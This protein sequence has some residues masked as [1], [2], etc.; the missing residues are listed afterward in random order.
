[1]RWKVLAT[2]AAMLTM[3]VLAGCAARGF[4]NQAR[5]GAL[6]AGEAALAL[7]AAEHD[8]YAAQVPGYGQAEHLKVLDNVTKVL[9]AARGYERA[10]ANTPSGGSI[11]A[12]VAQAVKAVNLA[13]DDLV[14]VI[15]PLA[16]VQAQLTKAIDIVRA[17]VGTSSPV[18][19][20]QGL[21]L[22]SIFAL[23]QV[24]FGLLQSGR[25]TLERLKA[26]L[27]AEGA[28]DAE[29]ADV[30]VRLSAAIAANEAEQAGG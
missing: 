1:M 21:P 24:V 19:G 4:R 20:A 30:D 8:I 13:L 14:K 7:N 6:T 26:L 10:V 28:T 17:V 22:A 15:P 25:T 27:K 18:S 16:N 23:L 12:E 9:Y 2:V 5:V 3:M 29:L 11:P